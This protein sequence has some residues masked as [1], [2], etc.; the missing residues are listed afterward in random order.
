[1]AKKGYL[2]PLDDGI[3]FPRDIPNDVLRACARGAAEADALRHALIRLLWNEAADGPLT[4]G[5][6]GDCEAEGE[7]P[8]PVCEAMRALGIGQHWNSAR[9]QAYATKEQ[10]DEQG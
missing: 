9:F 10:S 8:Y 4:D 2:G 5:C 6:D 3:T 1:M 7:P